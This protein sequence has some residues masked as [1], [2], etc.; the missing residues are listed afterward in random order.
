M[1]IITN[2]DFEADVSGLK[3]PS[4]AEYR[5]GRYLCAMCQ[6]PIGLPGT[7]IHLLPCTGVGQEYRLHATCFNSI[8]EMP[9]GDRYVPGDGWVEMSYLEL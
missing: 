9:Y 4:P 8:S 1:A 3:T 5:E 2:M 6:K 7:R